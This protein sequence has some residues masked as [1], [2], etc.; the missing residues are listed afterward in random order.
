MERVNESKARRGAKSRL[1]SDL[2]VPLC[3]WRRRRPNSLAT[4]HFIINAHH[5]MIDISFLKY[6]AQ[7]TGPQ[8]LLYRYSALTDHLTGNHEQQRLFD[9]HFCYLRSMST[10]MEFLIILLCFLISFINFRSLHSVIRLF[11]QKPTNNTSTFA[12]DASSHAITTAGFLS[13]LHRHGTHKH[14]QPIIHSNRIHEQF[15]VC[16]LSRLLFIPQTI[17]SIHSPCARSL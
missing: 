2:M 17:H 5:T 7:Q 3:L 6:L 14:T 1:N 11:R 15:S 12:V 10:A 9:I 4:N 13:H 16:L 8:S